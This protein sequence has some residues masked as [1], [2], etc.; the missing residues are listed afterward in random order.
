MTLVRRLPYRTHFGLE[1]QL[2]DMQRLM[3]SLLAH[4]ESWRSPGEGERQ[5]GWDFD[6]AADVYRDDGDLVVE[7]ELPGIDV[8]NDV[9]IEIHDGVLV[10]GGRRSSERS[11]EN[12]GVYLTE[13]RTGR[14]RR[15][16]SLPDGVDVDAVTATYDD[17]VMKV[18]VPLPEGNSTENSK[19]VEIDGG[20][21][22]AKEATVSTEESK[23]PT[24]KSK[25]PTAESKKSAKK[26]GKSAA[27]S[28][29]SAATSKK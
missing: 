11:E 7:L 2:L 18:R 4:D 21:S 14:F 19:R 22:G 20:T 27:K 17:G 26:S 12:E 29:K 23:K 9:D 10:I 8:D 1:R 28:K 5:D 25:K 13:R 6:P 3:S 24:A 15:T 16:M